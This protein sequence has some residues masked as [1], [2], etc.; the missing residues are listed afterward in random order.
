MSRDKK[1]GIEDWI[2]DICILVFILILIWVVTGCASKKKAIDII[3]VDGCY[4]HASAVEIESGQRMW[5]EFRIG[6]D[7]ALKKNDSIR[8]DDKDIN[9]RKGEIKDEER[10]N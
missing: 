7:C 1:R 3:Y 6:P 9:L 8:T 4:L 5:N 10:N 2:I